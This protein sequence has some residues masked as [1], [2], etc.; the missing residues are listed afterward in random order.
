MDSKINPKQVDKKENIEGIYAS[1]SQEAMAVAQDIF[2]IIE[3]TPLDKGK[4]MMI[5]GPERS[6]KSAVAINLSKIFLANG[7]KNR[8]W[9]FSQPAVD[10][11]DV[12]KDK[13]FSRVGSEI[14]A[15]SFESRS[16]IERL[17]Y[18]NEIVIM[19]E[20][21]FTPAELQSYL[22][23]ELMLFIERGGIFV[24]IGLHN[25]SQGGEFIFSALLKS[26]ADK[27]FQ[28]SAVCQMCGRKASKYSQ[29]L[30]DGVPAGL[31]VPTL[32]SP[33]FKVTYEPRCDDCF[34]VK[35]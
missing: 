2:K 3:S 6:G 31:E 33:S 14:V 34:V 30:I 9:V 22:L 12:P 5:I 7:T 25:T 29:R 18:D 1:I 21:H 26:R 27:I 8:K 16:D 4:L 20:I 13:I 32:L 19:D 24:G 28:V 17:F 15:S 11:P 23:Y 35:K 10:R